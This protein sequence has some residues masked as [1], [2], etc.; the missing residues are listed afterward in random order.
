[1]YDD[2]NPIGRDTGSQDAF[3]SD[4]D[5]LLNETIGEITRKGD[6]NP[7]FSLKNELFDWAEMAAQVLITIVLVFIFLIRNT[8]V[9]GHSMEPTLYNGAWVMISN[10]LYTPD[11]GDIVVLTKYG[12][13]PEPGNGTAPIVKRIIATGGQTVDIDFDKHTVMVDGVVLDEPY[14]NA[15]T[16]RRGSMSFPLFVPE[17]YIFVMGDNRNRSTDSRWVE[18]G[19]VDERM[20]L[21]KVLFKLPT[22]GLGNTDG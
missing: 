3:E 12:F 15:P 22:F 4:Y 13:E 11:N 20:V 18:V 19:L 17:G 2:E 9:K 1:M 16:E 8:G 14:I 7:A 21:G 6:P 5:E 10:L